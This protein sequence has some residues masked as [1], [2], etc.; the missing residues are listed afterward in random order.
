MVGGAGYFGGGGGSEENS[1]RFSGGGGSSGFIGHP[2]LTNATA[3]TGHHGITSPSATTQIP[4]EMLDKPYVTEAF[5]IWNDMTTQEKK[6]SAV[7]L[8]AEA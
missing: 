3:I 7:V 6:F 5:E 4:T 2:S 8:I 1:Y